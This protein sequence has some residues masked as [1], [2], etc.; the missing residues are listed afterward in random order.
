MTLTEAAT[1]N[2]VSLTVQALLKSHVGVFWGCDAVH[3]HIG[4]YAK[5]KRAATI[6]RV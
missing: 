3:W 2:G 1:P 5:E 4:T 6:P